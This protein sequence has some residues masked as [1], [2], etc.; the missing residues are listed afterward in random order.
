M[1]AVPTPR[2]GSTPRAAARIRWRA[3]ARA[4][5]S[6]IDRHDDR[7]LDPLRHVVEVLPPGL[8]AGDVIVERPAGPDV[9]G[10]RLTGGRVRDGEIMTVRL[11]PVGEDAARE[12]HRGAEL[13]IATVLRRNGP[14]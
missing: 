2:P 6:R 1:P 11:L 12:E 3:V 10:D 14:P 4:S 7:R 13:A 8:R 9:V 5:A